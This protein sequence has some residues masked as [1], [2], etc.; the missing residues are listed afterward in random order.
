M[1]IHSK[2]TLGSFLFGPE[3]FEENMTNDIMILFSIME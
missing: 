2:V 1:E 3:Y